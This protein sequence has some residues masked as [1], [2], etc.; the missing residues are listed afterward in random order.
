MA[1]PFALAPDLLR[2]LVQHARAA[3]PHEICGVLGAADRR[4]VAAIDVTNR[5]PNPTRFDADPLGLMH[6][7]RELTRRRLRLAGYYH[8]HPAGPPVPSMADVAS[9][10][11]PG[12]GPPLRLIVCPTG[13]WA[14]Y[15]TRADGWQVVVEGQSRATV[16]QQDPAASG[17]DA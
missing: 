9:E 2:S 3:S 1:P 6:A 7:E 8:S 17:R 4:I 16:P 11:W 12:C 14:L 13:R 5:S 10:L 15:E